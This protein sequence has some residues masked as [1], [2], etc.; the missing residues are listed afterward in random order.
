MPATVGDAE[1]VHAARAG[2]AAALGALLERHR[3]PLYA[4]ALSILCE[5]REAQDAV[6]DAFVTA[7]RHIE[8]LRDPAAFA[9][10]MHA[11]VRNA[12]RMR[13]RRVSEELPGDLPEDADAVA[14]SEQ[15]LER[16]AL[17]DWVWTALEQL[18]EDLRVTT[19]LRYFT[20]HASYQE[21]AATLG[22]PVG[23]VRSRIN[24]AKARLADALLATAASVHLD[25][26]RLIEERR[27]Q[28]SAITDEIYSTGTATLYLADCA[29][30]VLVEAPALDYAERGPDD[31]RRGVEDSAAAGVRL[32]LT[33]VVAGPSVTIFEGNYTN[34][35][36]DPHHC[37]ATHT[38]VRVHPNGRTTRLMLYYPPTVTDAAASDAG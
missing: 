7:L 16:L 27:L 5:R 19:M 13:L 9:G 4:A 12:C 2:D 33:G 20:R 8:D 3:A 32:D 14:D 21:I 10:W 36:G 6:Q 34:P 38:E 29:T 37:P 17:S 1:L 25:H 24:Q 26:N 15:A 35:P 28:W 23:T 18:P 30:D 31:H 11:I 22:I